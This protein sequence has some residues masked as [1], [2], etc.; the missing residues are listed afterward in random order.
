MLFIA[1]DS[2]TKSLLWLPEVT[3][4]I[5][6]LAHCRCRLCVSSELT[7][8]RQDLSQSTGGQVKSKAVLSTKLVRQHD[9]GRL[10]LVPVSRAVWVGQWRGSGVWRAVRRVGWQDTAVGRVGS[11]I[12]CVSGQ[13]LGAGAGDEGKQSK[14]DL[15][16]DGLAVS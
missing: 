2:L 7:A 9:V 10:L 16:V 1:A 8:T 4:G 6:Q 12:G 15:Q 5:G 13:V 11:W 3:L 14:E